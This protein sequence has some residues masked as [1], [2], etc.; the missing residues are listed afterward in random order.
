L[1]RDAPALRSLLETA[2]R[3]HVRGVPLR[4]DRLDPGD[5]HHRPFPSYPWQRQ[6]FWAESG[7]ARAIRLAGPAHALLGT[8][9]QGGNPAWLSDVGPHT[10]AFLCDHR[11]DERAVFPAAGYVETM[12]A[13]VAQRAEG[14]MLELHDVNF[15]RVL[16]LDQAQLLETTFDERSR[17][18]TIR[19][20]P[21]GGEGEW[22][23][24]AHARVPNGE[25][26]RVGPTPGGLPPDACAIDV[27]ALYAR[28][29]R[30]G[31]DYGPA[32]RSLRWAAT[33]GTD[34]WGRIAIDP[35]DEHARMQWHVH[36]SILDAAF[37]LALASMQADEERESKYLPVH[38]ERVQW[39]R[40][41]T[42]EV[43]CRVSNI[44][45]QDVRSH[46][47][48]EIFTLAGEPVAALRGA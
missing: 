12:L 34:L 47:D 28:F 45:H 26:S 6:R 41:A 17:T 2:G 38:I 30:A 5:R 10:H 21:A 36:P 46:A 23:T 27:D 1:K 24:H 9:A 33:A 35:G 19:C 25:S 39:L 13:A 15:E 22:Q 18:L 40:P 8:R 42:E 3:L 48:V 32:F 44:H 31:H 43:L 29:A 14:Y 11:L 37:H 7:D 16:R 20:K 4:W